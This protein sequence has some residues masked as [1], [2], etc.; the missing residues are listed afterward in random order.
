M[1]RTPMA[2]VPARFHKFL[3]PDDFTRYG[4][5]LD[6]PAASPRYLQIELTDLC[7][8]ACAGCVRAS[9]ESTGSTF[10]F[11]DFVRLLDDMP[12]LTQVSFVGAGEA[13]IVRDLAR[14][15]EECT[16]RGI[17]S[18]SNT[19]GLLVA[20]RLG[21]VVEAGLG[22]LAVSVDGADDAT[23]ADM[24]SGLRLRQLTAS[25]AAAV[26][27]TS[28]TTTRLSA[29]V[30]LSL[31]NIAGFPGIVEYL[32]DQGVDEVSVESLHHWG[33]DKTLNTESLF[34]ADP[35]TVV[36]HL[37]R[38]LEVALRRGLTVRVF[39]Y[40]RLGDPRADQVCPWP[41]DAFY[42]TRD[43]RAT[44]CC[45][46][47]EADDSNTIGNVLEDS[48]AAIWTGQRLTDLRAGLRHGG[49]WTSCVDC[50]YRREFGHAR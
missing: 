14:Y 10:S 9:H 41:W 48:V 50:V 8:L 36:P 31:R 2:E 38:G 18:S 39:D 33:D 40:R 15:V 28:G 5:S 35:A 1:S 20:R 37:E 11:P 34:A 42:V 49:G 6:T 16:R 7:N 26:R 32:A 17:L 21:P 46:Q 19:N 43:G 3:V 45:V 12:E 27:I 23:L 29:A 13:L 22:M 47:I 24:R 4:L 30:T 44:P 25:I